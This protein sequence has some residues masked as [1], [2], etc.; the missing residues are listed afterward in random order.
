MIDQD[1]PSNVI[2]L[3][4][5]RVQAET[6]EDDEGEAD[7]DASRLCSVMDDGPEAFVAVMP[8]PTED[9][10]ACGH[11]LDPEDAEMLGMAL[12]RAA[13]RV[14]ELRGEEG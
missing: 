6:D 4:D 10:E 13:G 7:F 8:G 11:A 3:S 2:R 12:I 5:R 14:R 9:G 1:D